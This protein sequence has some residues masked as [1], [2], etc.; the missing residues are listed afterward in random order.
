[1]TTKNPFGQ[2]SIKRD[3][4]DEDHTTHVQASTATTAPLF[5][6]TTQDKKK[7][8]IRPEDK[9]KLEE[10][11]GATL[12]AN[13]NEDEGFEVV[14]SK[15]KTYKPRN[16]TQDE[17]VTDDKLRKERHNKGKYLE[18]NA[19]VPAGKRLYDR[20]SGTGRGKEIAKGGAGGKHTW[21][22][23]SKTVAKEFEK[24][25][26]DVF[27][28]A[29][30]SYF[31]NAL[32][33]KPRQRREDRERN[34]NDNDNKEQRQEGDQ[35]A[36]N[37]EVQKVEDNTETRTEEQGQQDVDR[38]QDDQGDRRK[39]KG[40]EEEPVKEEDLLKRPEN[41][42]SLAE[43][44]AQLKANNQVL[45]S[46][47]KQVTRND[48]PNLVLKEKKDEEGLGIGGGVKKTQ[49]KIK[50]RKVDQKEVELNQIVGNSLKTDDGYERRDYND[51]S[52]KGYQGNSYNSKKNYGGN[53]FQF[54]EE[55]F[56]E[57]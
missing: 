23:N 27:D 1:M 49:K 31:N 33:P 14:G 16:N 2:L 26:T 53:R 3:A 8:K 36:E 42:L 25:N 13:P 5:S 32:N 35:Q 57:L 18:R 15:K 4:E 6:N 51:K 50:E 28:N 7:K 46:Q 44:K 22:N 11:T 43:Y 29:D 39:R 24:H 37:T 20:H 41:A 38:P 55:D 30:E 34:F 54:K 47:P 9:K 10:S 17:H 56:P 21:G 48:D 19:E 40:R 52:N 45:T 12:N